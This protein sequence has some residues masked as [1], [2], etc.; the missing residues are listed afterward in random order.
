[1]SMAYVAVA[2]TVV[3]GLYTANTQRQQ[4]KYAAEQANA[5]AEAE[6]ARS[7]LEAERIREAGKKA[8]S[9]AA[10]QAADNGLNLGVGS[11][12]VIDQEIAYESEQ[13]AWMTRLTGQSNA[14]RISSQGRA[15]Q[16]LANT[17]A[18]GTLLQAAASSYS[19]YK[20]AQAAKKKG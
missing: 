12:V 20:G 13:D 11:P 5:D 10:A 16:K 17:Q 15:E 8:R 6:A 9:A 1:M 2:A 14:A 19:G 4:G 18:T 7:R 3:S